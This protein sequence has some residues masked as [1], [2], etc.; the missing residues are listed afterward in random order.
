MKFFISMINHPAYSTYLVLGVFAVL[1]ALLYGK[2]L[3]NDFIYDDYQ[4]IKE[5]KYIQSLVYLPKVVTGCT[6]EHAFGQ[7]EGRA[8]YYR[9]VQNLSYLITYQISSSPWAF[10]LVN[11]LYLYGIGTLLFFVGKAITR[12]TLFAFVA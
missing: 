4:Q 3:P 9:P 5:N 6:W 7:C 8:L 2:T 12:N 11:L 10:H 1:I